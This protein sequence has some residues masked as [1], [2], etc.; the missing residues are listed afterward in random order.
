M[1]I[2]LVIA[3]ILE[4]PEIEY[5]YATL[6]IVGGAFV[7]LPFVYYKIRFKIIGKII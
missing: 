3:P 5:L 4:N 2:Y 1:S 7:Y 6:Y